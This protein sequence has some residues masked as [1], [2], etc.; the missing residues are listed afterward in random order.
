MRPLC[1][2]PE[3]KTLSLAFIA[4]LVLAGCARIKQWAYE[5]FDR[6]S[7]Q[8]PEKVIAALEIRQGDHIADLGSGS[9]YFTFRLARAVGPTG[10]IYAVDIDP[11]MNDLVAKRSREQGFDNIQVILAEPDDPKLV[12]GSVDLIFTVNT[13]HHIDGRVAY[14][15]KLQRYLRPGGRLAIIDFDRRAWFQGLWSHYTP[16]EFIR[17]EMEQ[18]GYRLQ[19][20]FAFLDRQSFQIFVPTDKQVKAEAEVKLALS[21]PG[22]SLNLNLFSSQTKRVEDSGEG[23]VPLGRRGIEKGGHEEIDR[24]VLRRRIRVNARD[25]DWLAVL[26]FVQG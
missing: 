13:Y 15:R 5:G 20:E 21:L 2:T 3:A 4:L 9:G 7:W 17:R 23:L 26:P 8:A 1:R 16:P 22:V 14:F 11:E 12:A 25:D 6:D 18:A 19:R 10:R 24:I